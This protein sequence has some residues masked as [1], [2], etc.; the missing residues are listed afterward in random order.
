M[1]PTIIVGVDNSATAAAAADRAA[2]LAT[3]LGADLHVVTA[4]GREEVETV[5]IGHE[6]FVLSSA[7]EATQL[8]ES[9]AAR[10]SVEHPGLRLHTAALEGRAA[11]AI[12]DHAGAIGA[13][14]IVIGNKRV[15]GPARVLGSIATA[16][17]HKAPCD[18]YV[19]HTHDN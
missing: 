8:T 10:L 9:V 15:Q 7:D 4:F 2:V 11:A 14:L 19:A 6:R 16:V 5:E 17:L 13:D 12:T 1:S 18:V 3:A